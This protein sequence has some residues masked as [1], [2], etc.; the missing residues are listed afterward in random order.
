[1]RLT[2]EDIASSDAAREG[3]TVD[4]QREFR[5]GLR[6]MLEEEFKLAFP[7]DNMPRFMQRRLTICND[8]LPQIPVCL[9]FFF[10]SFLCF[11][12]LFY[13]LF[14][15]FVFVFSFRFSFVFRFLFSF[16][17]FVFFWFSFSLCTFN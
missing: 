9:S 8:Q 14:V 11:Y 2:E 7:D 10:F 15:F 17:F 13:L 3:T 6:A 4:A 5:A 12:L 16:S 1:M